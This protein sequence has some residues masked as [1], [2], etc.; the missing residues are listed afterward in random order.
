MNKLSF[1]EHQMWTSVD[2]MLNVE[3]R[4]FNVLNGNRKHQA[5]H[6]GANKSV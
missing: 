4:P 6:R 2:K 3:N 1:V 5:I